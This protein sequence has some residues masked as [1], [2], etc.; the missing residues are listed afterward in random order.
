MKAYVCLLGGCEFEYITSVLNHA[1]ARN[2]DE[3]VVPFARGPKNDQ[4]RAILSKNS[5]IES[6]FEGDSA[7]YRFDLK[8]QR[9]KPPPQ[10]FS[11][12]E[13]SDGDIPVLSA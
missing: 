2:V 1:R 5:F 12:I 7:I 9:I 6:G 13:Q 4:K 10:W 8:E 11:R 3:A